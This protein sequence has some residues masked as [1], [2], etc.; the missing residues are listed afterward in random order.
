MSHKYDSQKGRWSLSRLS[1][2]RVLKGGGNGIPF[3]EL[4][5][6]LKREG[7]YVPSEKALIRLLP[8]LGLEFDSEKGLVYVPE[9]RQ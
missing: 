4:V 5:A 7:Y 6:F 1:K 3:T 2:Q 8:S 9:G